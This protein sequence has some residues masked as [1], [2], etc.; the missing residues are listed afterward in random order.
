MEQKQFLKVNLSF[1]F[2]DARLACIAALPRLVCVATVL[3]SSTATWNCSPLFN[4]NII[5]KKYSVVT[6]MKCALVS[7][8]VSSLSQLFLFSLPKEFVK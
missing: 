2:K 7:S 8:I 5:P 3:F 1:I 4:E 6:H